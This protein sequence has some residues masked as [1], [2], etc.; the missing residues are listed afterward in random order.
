MLVSGDDSPHYSMFS[1]AY[2]LLPESV[3]SRIACDTEWGL[4][5]EEYP[6]ELLSE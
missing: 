5:H 2:Q 4:A 6:A 3:A 1:K